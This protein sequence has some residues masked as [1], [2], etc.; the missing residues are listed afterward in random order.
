MRVCDV[1]GCGKALLNP[2]AVQIRFSWNSILD[3]KEY[4]FCCDKCGITFLTK[5]WVNKLIEYGER[6]VS[7]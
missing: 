1:E 3:G 6:K 5:N 4:E 7:K 2:P